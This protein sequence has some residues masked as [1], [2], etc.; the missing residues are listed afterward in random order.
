MFAVC[1]ADQL[2]GGEPVPIL[3]SESEVNPDSYKYAYET[4]NGI[5]ASEQGQLKNAGAENAAIVSILIV[6]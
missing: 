4:G 1:A 5:S 6:I 3:R 2:S